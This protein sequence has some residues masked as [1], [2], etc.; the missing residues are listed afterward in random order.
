M[1]ALYNYYIIIILNDY[2][3]YYAVVNKTSPANAKLD[4]LVV[5]LISSLVPAIILLCAIIA[6]LIT[7]VVILK[8]RLVQL[9]SSSTVREEDIAEYANTPI[10][11]S[12]VQTLFSIAP[13]LPRALLTTSLNESYNTGHSVAREVRE[14]GPNRAEG[15]PSAHLDED[16]AYWNDG[17]GPTTDSAEPALVNF[18]IETEYN[19]SYTVVASRSN[20][21]TNQ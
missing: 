4:S 13:P 20:D 10:V 11:P 1:A 21:N 9:K 16:V 6:L 15:L 7:T 3:L 12:R 18:L 17:L 5:A 19:E 8:K 14:S 2:V